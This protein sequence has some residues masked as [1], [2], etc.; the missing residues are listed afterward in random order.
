MPAA[1]LLTSLLPPDR[2]H[3][4]CSP[5]DRIDPNET[6]TF[7]SAVSTLPSCSE[8]LRHCF[9]VRGNQAYGLAS[10]AGASPLAHAGAAFASSTLRGAAID[11]C[12]L[13]GLVR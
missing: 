12:A 5:A 8:A 7:V 4:L 10:A 9:V 6:E 3:R 1:A 2:E 13:C 11:E